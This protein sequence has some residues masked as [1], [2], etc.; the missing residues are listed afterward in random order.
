MGTSIYWTFMVS[1]VTTS[2]FCCSWPSGDPLLTAPPFVSRRGRLAFWL[3]SLP[4]TSPHMG[5][6]E[7]PRCRGV[8]V[9]FPGPSHSRE[10]R[11]GETHL[12]SPSTETLLRT[13]LL[14]FPRE[15]L[16]LAYLGHVPMSREV[17]SFLG[18][19]AGAAVQS[20]QSTRGIRRN[21]SR[22]LRA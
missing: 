1:V 7:Q 13:T 3:A 8:G 6:L 9:H 22:P 19:R 16:L 12:P 5:R 17:L 20:L 18:Q 14:G 10:A 2:C 4:Y 15:S 21:G 11:C